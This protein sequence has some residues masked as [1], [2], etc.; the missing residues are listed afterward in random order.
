MANKLVLIYEEAFSTPLKVVA[1]NERD[2]M[3]YLSENFKF[4]EMSI[5]R[6]MFISYKTPFGGKEL[7]QL[8][9]VKEI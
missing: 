3:D 1:N 9:W 4:T 5:D 7:I 2:L 8:H 6:D